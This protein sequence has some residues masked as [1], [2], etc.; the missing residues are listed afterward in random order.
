MTRPHLY[1]L[2]PALCG[3]LCMSLLTIPSCGIGD[4]PCQ[5]TLPPE[6]C[7]DNEAAVQAIMDAHCAACHGQT[8]VAGAPGG[9]RLD[10][11]DGAMTGE[12]GT[13]Q[14]RDRVTIRSLDGTMPPAGLPALTREQLETLEEWNSCQ[15]SEDIK[16]IKSMR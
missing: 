2:I 10:I 9:F 3:A 7:G 12:R 16:Q 5:P 1:W 13:L 15:C 4:Q 11:Y 8:P 6:A 14:T